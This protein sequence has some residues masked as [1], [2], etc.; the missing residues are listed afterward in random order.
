MALVFALRFTVLSL[1]ML[2]LSI[3]FFVWPIGGSREWETLFVLFSVF[4]LLVSGVLLFIRFSRHLH[5]AML[6]LPVVALAPW[7]V[8]WAVGILLLSL[9]GSLEAFR[10]ESGGVS[11]FLASQIVVVVGGLGMAWGQG[12][13]WVGAFWLLTLVAP[14][15]FGFGCWF[16]QRAIK[17]E[18]VTFDIDE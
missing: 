18:M 2:G 10:R 6:L 4:S 1:A 5:R 13:L 17:S 12:W 15:L 7:Q 14:G 11:W 3:T 8:K 9:L 16:W